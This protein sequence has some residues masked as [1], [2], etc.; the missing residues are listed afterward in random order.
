MRFCNNSLKGELNF[1]NLIN[2][3]LIAKKSL[4]R[5]SI[6]HKIYLQTEQDNSG[7]GFIGNDFWSRFFLNSKV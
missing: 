5:V 2:K 4:K 7:S 6:L 1:A 3:L